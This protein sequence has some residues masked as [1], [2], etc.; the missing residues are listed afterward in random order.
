MKNRRQ[1]DLSRVNQGAGFGFL[2]KIPNQKTFIYAYFMQF[3]VDM[4]R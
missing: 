2:E 1:P 3:Y 4:S